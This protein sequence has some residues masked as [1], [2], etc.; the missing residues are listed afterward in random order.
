MIPDFQENTS[1]NKNL[2]PGQKRP[3]SAELQLGKRDA[4]TRSPG[5][6]FDIDKLTDTI[7][8][9]LTAIAGLFHSTK[10]QAWI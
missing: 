5:K 9:E 1:R 2:F 8:G 6:T 3:G 4:T 10:W 7:T